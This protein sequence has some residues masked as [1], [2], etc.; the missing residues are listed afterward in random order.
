MATDMSVAFRYA[1]MRVRD[2]YDVD[3]PDP[4]AIENEERWNSAQ[5]AIRHTLTELTTQGLLDA[6]LNQE[7]LS[8][9]VLREVVT[10]GALDT[11]LSDST[12]REI[13]VQG[14]ETIHADNGRGLKLIEGG[15]SC[16]ENLLTVA[17]RLL[18]QG[19]E[20]L[21]FSK[22]IQTATL[23]DGT[24]VTVIQPPVA[25]RGLIIE[26][27]R[28][29]AQPPSGAE[30]VAQNVISEEMLEL[31]QRAVTAKRNIVVAGSPGSGVTTLLNVL[32]GLC[33][34]HERVVTIERTPTLV[35][36]RARTL[37]LRSSRTSNDTLMQAQS[38][39]ADR[40]VVDGAAAENLSS[41]LYAMAERRVG[42]FLGVHA[43]S[44]A[45]LLEALQLFSHLAGR[46]PAATAALIAQAANLV[47]HIHTNDDGSHRVESVA[48]IT[49]EADQV[50]IQELYTHKG[51]EFKATAKAASYLKGL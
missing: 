6:T 5:Q 1:G 36:D 3:N 41:V 34:E 13:V 39:R 42:S 8:A 31:F 24:H 44:A 9:L 20:V 2:N 17:R 7:E 27:R 14:L 45:D 22:P 49:H 11:L 15:F 48:E 26:I 10:F 46:E 28:G 30:L 38:M 25:A 32:I 16:P 23:P 18:A 35:V 12:V 51:G 43:T 21:D 4:Y 40:L 19:H 33:P 50:A 29:S 37:S 47:I